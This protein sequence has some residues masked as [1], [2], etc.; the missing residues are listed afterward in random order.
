[1]GKTKAEAADPAAVE[2]APAETSQTPKVDSARKQAWDN[3]LAKAREDAEKNGT[4]H[5]FEAQEA[6]GE[7]DKIPASFIDPA[8]KK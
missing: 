2:T 1:M 4:L 5:V 6:N 8:F 7:F 3:F